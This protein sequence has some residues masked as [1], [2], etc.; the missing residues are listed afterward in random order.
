MFKKLVLP[1][2]EPLRGAFNKQYGPI[3]YYH[4]AGSLGPVLQALHPDF[5]QVVEI[6]GPR[7]A[8][9]HR[10][11]G[12]CVNLNLYSRTGGG[13][14]HFWQ[15]TA[16]T[17]GQAYETEALANIFKEEDLEHVNSF[18]AKDGDAYLMSGQCIHSVEM[19][20]ENERTFVQLSWRTASFETLLEQTAEYHS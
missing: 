19:P 11:H 14:T 4:F 5:V 9:P 7:R 17:I 6:K 18:T 13:V 15:E 3:H 8:V 2:V 1:M 20:P 12:I 16:N 10:D